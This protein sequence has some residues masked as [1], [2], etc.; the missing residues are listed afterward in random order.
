MSSQWTVVR[1][2]AGDCV[3]VD[4]DSRPGKPRTSTDKRR[5]KFVADILHDNTRPHIADV[6]IKQL[7][8]YGWKVLLNA[9]YSSDMS[10]PDFDVFPKL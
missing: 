1:F 10:P 8:D 5:V 7:R 6:V 2:L 3:S 4:N 9:P